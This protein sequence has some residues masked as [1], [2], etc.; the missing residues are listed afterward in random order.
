M[1]LKS[2]SMG[3]INLDTG[4]N[5]R[6]QQVRRKVPWLL[7]TLYAFMLIPM[8]GLFNSTNA[9]CPAGTECN[10][11]ID[12][13]LMIQLNLNGP[14]VA[15]NNSTI[16]NV[17]SAAGGC[18]YPGA[19]AVFDFLVFDAEPADGDTEAAMIRSFDCADVGGTFTRW[20]VLEDQPDNNEVDDCDAPAIALM[21]TVVDVDDPAIN[22]SGVGPMCLGT[23]M[24]ETNTDYDFTGAVNMGTV[25]AGMTYD[26]ISNLTWT[27]PEF[28]D[29]CGLDSIVISFTA[30]AGAPA[31]P[32]DIIYGGMT[33][34]P[35]PGTPSF[36]VGPVAFSGDP[37]NCPSTT[38]VT[39][40]LTDPSG[41]TTSCF[42]DVTVTDNELPTWTNPFPELLDLVNSETASAVATPFV[43]GGPSSSSINIVLDCNA[44]SYSADS[45]V[46][47]N[48][49]PEATDNCD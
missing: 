23:V 24:L 29:N 6:K 46:L 16:S 33:G 36:D 30:Q 2:T 28:V 44:P 15:L 18:G 41:A 4:S 7:K 26:C 17:I 14:S 49:V 37:E 19:T 8:L 10:A 13:P 48:F 22:P 3:S 12:G 27:T 32:D 9:Q 40:T 43:G 45:L 21:I 34:D 38:R 11:S 25:D 35:L 5:S 47:A 1:I 39:Y 42:F 31:L 20:V